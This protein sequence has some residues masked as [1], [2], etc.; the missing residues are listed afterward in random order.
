MAA[1]K[2]SRSTYRR[3]ANWSFRGLITN[4]KQ[5]ADYLIV[6]E[7]VTFDLILCPILHSISKDEQS[8]S[9]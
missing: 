6:C 5:T 7:G 3:K 9:Y 2:T 1:M 4:A 8:L